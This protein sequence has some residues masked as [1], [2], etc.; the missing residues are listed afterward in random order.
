MLNKLQNNILIGGI[1]MFLFLAALIADRSINLMSLSVLIAFITQMALM[2]Y[3]SRPDHT[4][5]SERALFFTVLIYTLLL[6]VFDMLVCEYY[7]GDNYMFSK[8]DALFYLHESTHA[9][10]LGLAEGIKYF[11]ERYEFDDWGALVFDM[12]VMYVLP[13]KLFLNAIYTVLGAISAVYIYRIGKPYMPEVHAFLASLAYAT[14]SY[15][16]FFNCSFLKESLFIFLVIS[17]F[18]HFYN[19]INNHSQES[20][21][22]IGVCIVIMFFFRPAVSAF[23]GASIFAYYAL[24]MKGHAVSLFLYGIIAVG[25]V[26]SMQIMQSNLDRY[27]VNGDMGATLEYRAVTNYSTGFNYFVSY[28]GAVCGPFPTL[29][30]KSP[31]NHSLLE[32]YGA[33]LTYRLFLIIPFWASLYYAW[34]NKVVAFLP[35]IIFILMEMVSTAFIY[36]SLELRKVLLHIPFM[37][38]LSF[39]GLKYIQQGKLN[40]MLGMPTYAMA[41]GI[42]YLWNIIK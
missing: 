33:G 25:G 37:Y 12:L 18:Y 2:I 26:I 9:A 31:D 32:Y 17:T 4:N 23:I 30:P 15:M 28:F 5:Y 35:L 11:A 22:V 16:I 7:E 20:F 6:G 3:Y 14:S 39:Y 1:L 29:F 27:A 13:S 10:N 41:I 42:L 21:V 34:K 24:Q 19:A 8:Q 36:A 40:F 38:I